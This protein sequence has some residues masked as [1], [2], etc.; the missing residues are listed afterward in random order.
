MF[1][2]DTPVDFVTNCLR[3]NVKAKKKSA[4]ILLFFKKV[5]LSSRQIRRN[6]IAV[7]N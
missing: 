1:P 7:Q 2:Q 3:I 5:F 6:K 4:G